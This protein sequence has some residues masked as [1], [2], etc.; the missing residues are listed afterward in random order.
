MLPLARRVCHSHRASGGRTSGRPGT[1]FLGSRV[2]AVHEPQSGP[3]PPGPNHP[4]PR[5][6][7]SGAGEGTFA[8]PGS[9]LSALVGAR[10]WA[11]ASRG[12]PQEW[13]RSPRPA[14]GICLW[15][16][17]PNRRWWGPGLVMIYSEG[18]RR[19]LGQTKL[20]PALGARGREVWG[21]IWDVI[22]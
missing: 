17:F 5:L 4:Q 19:M 11:A 10:D 2:V 12:A 21:E 1:D 3:Q 18:Y 8:V 15:W 22:G 6:S 16:R 13:R 20:P 14:V 7:V 9:E